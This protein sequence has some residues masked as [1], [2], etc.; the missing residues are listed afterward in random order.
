MKTRTTLPPPG[1]AV[2]TV[3]AIATIGTTGAGCSRIY[4]ECP[5]EDRGRLS[6]ACVLPIQADG[7]RL[8]CHLGG[9]ARPQRAPRG[10][11][12]MV[13]REKADPYLG[14]KSI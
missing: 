11:D 4:G 9:P 1:L 8:Q 6:A 3:R 7:I 13:G 2:L 14:G 10:S 5:T 12:Y